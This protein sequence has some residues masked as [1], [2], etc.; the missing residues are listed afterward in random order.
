M[1]RL[2]DTAKIKDLVNVFLF[3]PQEERMVMVVL[4]IV[5]PDADVA[6]LNSFPSR[7]RTQS[8]KLS[9]TFLLHKR[10]LTT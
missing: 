5:G 2:S 6:A 1:Q 10:C 9:M 8:P 4:F 7:Q 3:R